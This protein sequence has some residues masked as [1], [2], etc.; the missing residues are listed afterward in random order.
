MNDFITPPNHVNFLAKPIFKDLGKFDILDCTIANIEDNGGGPVE[1]HSHEH[2]HL[3]IVISGK[4]K[5]ILEDETII[6]NKN[7]YYLVKPN[8]MHKMWNDF[9]EKSIVMGITLK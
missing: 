8:S 4:V 5:V 2:M 3:F 9:G 6:L 1:L 7:D